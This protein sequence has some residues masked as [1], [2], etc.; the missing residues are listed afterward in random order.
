MVGGSGGEG[1]GK[2]FVQKGRTEWT[3]GQEIIRI[4]LPIVKVLTEMVRRA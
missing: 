1:S 2:D 4:G 3:V